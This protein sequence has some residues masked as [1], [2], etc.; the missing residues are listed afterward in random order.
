M[1]GESDT[2]ENDA[3]LTTLPLSFMAWSIVEASYEGA[4]TSMDNRTSV[5]LR[6]HLGL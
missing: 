2:I 1:A 4:S 5:R 6:P 3:H